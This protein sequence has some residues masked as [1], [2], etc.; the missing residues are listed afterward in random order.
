MNKLQKNVK[1]IKLQWQLFCTVMK[2]AST[3]SEQ[4]QRYI[5]NEVKLINRKIRSLKDEQ[6]TESKRL[7]R[8]N[9]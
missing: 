4:N 9:Y 8:I 5:W 3:E 2:I 1:M 7:F 6:T